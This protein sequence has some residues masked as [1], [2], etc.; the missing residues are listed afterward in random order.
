MAKFGRRR[1]PLRG[2]PTLRRLDH[3]AIFLLIGGT[4]TP[5]SLGMPNATLGIALL[6]VVW[7][8]VVTGASAELFRERG[9]RRWSV[10]WYLAA[11]WLVLPLIPQLIAWLPAQ[12]LG[13]LLLGGVCYS[14]GGVVY[15]TRR[16]DP[17][18]HV[19]GFH[20][21]FHILVIAGTASH[22]VVVARLAAVT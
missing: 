3:A 20:E 9:S 18:P 2:R 6:A 1:G 14:L 15:A 10:A 12:L 8:V 11:G 5:L 4:Y 19:W 22:A 21:I 17:F 13:L 7:T 16:P